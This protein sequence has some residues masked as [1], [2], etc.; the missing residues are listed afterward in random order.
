MTQVNNGSAVSNTGLPDQIRRPG[1]TIYSLL[2]LLLVTFTSLQT[3]AAPLENTLKNHPSPYLALHGNDPVAWQTWSNKVFARAKREGKLVYV[4]I[5]YFSCHWCHVMQ[6]ESYQN[7]AIAA[8]LNKYFI[9]V[10]VDRELQPALDTRMLEFVQATRGYSGWPA[11]VFMTPEGYP[12]VGMVY[13]KPKNFLAIL[14]KL[15]RQWSVRP[16]AL[17]A[18]ARKAKVQM[19]RIELSKG[20]DLN[21]GLGKRYMKN[22][23]RISLQTA[24][25]LNGGFGQ[26]TKF[27]NITQLVALMSYA[28]KSRDR[29]VLETIKLTLDRMASQGLYDHL[30]G[31]FF[32]YTVD[33]QWQTPHFEKML[34]DNA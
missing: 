11:N 15:H 23:V 25:D 3:F 26:K 19:V 27:P 16:A 33:S 1:S 21:K 12:L 14:N 7:P 24:D 9:P 18:M 10:K 4:S 17:R 6:K 29:K 5:G 28:K 20:P 34:Y 30:R 31:G 32:R 13:V 2:L 8:V 22:F